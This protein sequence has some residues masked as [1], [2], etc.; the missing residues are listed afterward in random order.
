MLLPSC[1][2]NPQPQPQQVLLHSR[3][4]PSPP[5]ILWV[6]TSCGGLNDASNFLLLWWNKVSSIGANAASM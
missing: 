3:L 4:L 2:C 5:A 1:S 6:P